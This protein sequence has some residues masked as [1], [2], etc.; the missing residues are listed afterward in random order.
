MRNLNEYQFGEW[1]PEIYE[2]TATYGHPDMLFQLYKRGDHKS[3]EESLTT[4][5]TGKWGWQWVNPARQGVIGGKYS[6]SDPEWNISVGHPSRR[7]AYNSAMDYML[8]QTGGKPERF[9][10]SGAETT[11][12]K[13]DIR[14]WEKF[15]QGLGH[16]I[17]YTHGAEPIDWDKED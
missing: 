12:D 9:N 17:K 16:E 11:L 15:H 4:E 7:A 14:K 3:A 10:S 2:E 8:D 6:L 5:K 1:R 13:D